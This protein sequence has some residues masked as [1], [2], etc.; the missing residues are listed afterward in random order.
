MK[1][2]LIKQKFDGIEKYKYKS[3]L[4][5]CND[6][7]ET[8]CISFDNDSYEN[9]DYYEEDVLPGFALFNTI[10]HGDWDGDYE[11][12]ETVYYKIS[13]C[14]FCGEPINI[15]VVDE[16]DLD[17]QYANIKKQREKL[18]ERCN[19]TDSKKKAAEL[20]KQVRELDKKI[21]WFYQ[22]TEYKSLV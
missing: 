20:E 9:V 8:P 15:T 13:H 19:K 10:T 12:E 16:E 14:P 2:E 7:K 11:W 22:L 5:C 17:E 4:W 1:I 18:W 3:F 21:D 6:I